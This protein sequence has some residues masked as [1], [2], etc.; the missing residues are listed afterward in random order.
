MFA[1]IWTEGDDST[2]RNKFDK[3]IWTVMTFLSDNNLNDT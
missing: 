3:N 1:R 2:M